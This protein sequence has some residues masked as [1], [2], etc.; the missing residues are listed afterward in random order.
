MDHAL[1]SDVAAQRRRRERLILICTSAPSFMLQL[2][3]NIVSVSLT[4]IAR[5]LHAGFSGIEWVITA[6]MLSF[7][8]LLMPAGALAD[9]FGRKQMLMLGLGIF[10][11]ASALC[12]A[13]WSLPVLIAARALQGAG[14]ALQLSSALATLSHSF[15]GE[16]RGR[17]FSFWGSVVGIGIAAG[18]VVGGLITQTFGWQW[19]FYVNL[20]VGIVLIAMIARVIESSRDPHAMRIDLPGVGCFAGALFLVTLALI[21]GTHRGWR[22][23]WIVGELV[24]AALLFALFVTVEQ[25][26]TRPML[27]L[28]YFR[29]PT[30]LGAVLAQFSFS[31]GMLTM[32]TFLPIFLQSGL[33][34]GSAIAGLMMLPMVVPLFVVPR[35]VS[36]HLAHRLSGRALLSLGLSLVCA[37]LIAF[38]LVANLLAYEPLVVGML[39]VGVGAGILNGET[40][41]VGMTVIPKE[42]SGMASGVSGTVRFTG[43]VLGIAVLGAVLYG[44]IERSVSRAL[45]AMST[46]DLLHLVQNI[47]AGHLGQLTVPGLDVAALH[48]LSV[49]S[50]AAGYQML[51]LC[52]ALFMLISAILTWKLVNP[53]ETP[54]ARPA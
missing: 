42:R 12:G 4:S 53:L 14:A 15:Q 1:A 54:P 26:Q 11:L 37:G 34:F 43:L 50:L 41:K 8:S 47:A 32:L 30:Y 49:H 39:L 6:Y 33:G 18:P 2:D 3:A 22:D 10:T 25:R 29:K 51:F 24:C 9:R 7:A 21:E 40:T 23:P 38:Y 27:E 31:I 36:R 20:P 44:S 16:A 46:S 45:P 52:A 35:L 28:Q 17:A 19:A 5:S 48:R 13:A